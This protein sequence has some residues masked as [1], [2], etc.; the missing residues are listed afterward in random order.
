MVEGSEKNGDATRETGD[1]GVDAEE[2]AVVVVEDEGERQYVTGDGAREL[3]D[4]K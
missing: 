3:F 2:D 4:A 1:A